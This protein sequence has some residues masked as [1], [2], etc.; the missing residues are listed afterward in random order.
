M[1]YIIRWVCNDFPDLRLAVENY[2]LN[3]FDPS[4]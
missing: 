1:L 3:N 2:V 4:R